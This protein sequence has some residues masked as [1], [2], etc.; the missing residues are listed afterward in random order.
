MTYYF[1]PLQTFAT[2]DLK[3]SAIR[4]R[5]NTVLADQT[6]DNANTY[7]QCQNTINVGALQVILARVHVV[8]VIDANISMPRSTIRGNGYML[9]LAVR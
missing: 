1:F 6:E 3:Y 5:M 9:P 7:T 8:H 2:S 4:S